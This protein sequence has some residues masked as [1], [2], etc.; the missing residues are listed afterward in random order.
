MAGDTNLVPDV[1]VRDLQTGS[2][3]RASVTAGGFNSS[4]FSPSISADGRYVAFHSGAADLVPGDNNGLNDVYV[5]DVQEGTTTRVSVSLAGGDPDH[6]SSVPS[7]SA[8]G[9]SVAFESQADNLVPGDTNGESDVFVRDMQTHT[10][11]RVSV[12]PLGR[13][14]PDWSDF[15]SISADGRYVAFESDATNLVSADGNDMRDVFVRSVGAPT[16]DWI[17]PSAVAR[18]SSTVVT[19]VGSGFLPG[20]QASAI[21]FGPGGVNVTSVTVIS[22]A[23]LEVVLNVDPAAAI[24]ARNVAVWN[25]GTGPGPLATSWGFCFGCLTVT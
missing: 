5:R 11:R 1:F 10:T 15:P 23:R 12:D 21:A 16:V 25:P 6:H 22:E 2:T 4:S 18:G 13:Q 3:T 14:A 9:R 17:A 19:V 7:I 20:A 8:D 24:G